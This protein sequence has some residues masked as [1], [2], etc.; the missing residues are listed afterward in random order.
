MG[1]AIGR[2]AQQAHS[3]LRD[4]AFVGVADVRLPDLGRAAAG[5]RTGHGV[6]HAGADRPD[7]GGVVLEAHHLLPALM[8]DQRRADRGKGLDHAAVHAA[9]HDAVGLVVLGGAIGL[10]VVLGGVIGLLL[11]LSLLLFA[12]LCLVPRT[13]H[14]RFG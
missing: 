2:H 1:Q 11:S 12:V 4:Q 13:E 8:G 10:L 3:S 9:V 7:E 6:E 5:D 14:G